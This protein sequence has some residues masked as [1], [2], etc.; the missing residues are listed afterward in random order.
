MCVSAQ[1]ISHSEFIKKD[2]KVKF[3]ISWKSVK[4]PPS[5]SFLGQEGV[6]RIL[7]VNSPVSACFS[8]SENYVKLRSWDKKGGVA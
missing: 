7:K 3:C 1:R 4:Q 8:K 2:V 5:V 6:F